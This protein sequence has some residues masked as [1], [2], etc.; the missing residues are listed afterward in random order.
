M[1]IILKDCNGHVLGDFYEWVLGFIK[2]KYK[3]KSGDKIF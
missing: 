2:M 3:P 1:I